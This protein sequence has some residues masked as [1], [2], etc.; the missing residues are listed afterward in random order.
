[1]ANWDRSNLLKERE[2]KSADID[3]KLIGKVPEPLRQHNAELEKLK[4]EYQRK[5]KAWL[6]V[7]EAERKSIAHE[8][9]DDLSQPL[10]ALKINLSGLVRRVTLGEEIS[11]EK[12]EQILELND[13]IIKTVKRISVELRPGVL[14][15]L[16]LIAAIEWQVGYF[17]DLTRIECEL[18]VETSDITIDEQIATV[19]FRIFQ[20]ILTNIAKQGKATRVRI[21]LKREVDKL[22]LIVVDNGDRKLEDQILDRQSFRL[23]AEHAHLFAGEVEMGNPNRGTLVMVNI[24]LNLSG[25]SL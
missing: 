25:G 21:S 23:I 11:L 6:Q 15:D 20:R 12:L 24:P 16:G 19:I 8:I 17:R 13:S 18:G 14:D 9:H 1:M 10:T 5:T 22:Q 2:M 7:E 4:V 3:K